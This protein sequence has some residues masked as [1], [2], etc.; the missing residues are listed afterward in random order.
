MTF[1][2]TYMTHDAKLI[3]AGASRKHLNSIMIPLANAN[4][5]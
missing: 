1:Y 5:Q 2:A 4:V 3:S